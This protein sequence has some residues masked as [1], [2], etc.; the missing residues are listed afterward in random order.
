VTSISL[1]RTELTLL[2]DND[3]T[4]TATV[5]PDD[6]TDK[7]VTWTSSNP[8]V[9]RVSGGWITALQVG[10]TTITA[11]VGGFS[12]TCKVTVQYQFSISPEQVTASGD[13]QE[14]TIRVKC[15]ET[16]QV[17]SMPE[18]ITQ[19][20]VSSKTHKFSAPRNPSKTE[21]SG[22]I[23]FLDGKGTRLTCMVT[24]G[25]YVTEYGDGGT[26]QVGEGEEIE[27]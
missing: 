25:G 4:L 23:V 18:W 17:E 27:W 24:Q 10:E 20:S 9:A 22:A 14:F 2:A 16:Y 21:R 11:S 15:P 13:G 6:A 19:V 1:N 8:S 5:K 3:A 26:E 7:T 12:A